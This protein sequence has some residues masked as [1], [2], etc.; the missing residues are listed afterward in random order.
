[1][2]IYPQNILLTIYNSLFVT[3][4]NYGSLV[5]GTN[6]SRISKIQKRVTQI[7]TDS[8][9]IVHTEPLFKNLKLLK[10]R[11]YVLFKKF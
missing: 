2:F 11:R 8:H 6:I 5:W 9:Y 1:M 7:I 10:S 3:H 4:I